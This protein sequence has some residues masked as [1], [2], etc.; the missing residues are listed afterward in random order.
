MLK[1]IKR[2]RNLSGTLVA[3]FSLLT[4]A[5]SGQAIQTITDKNDILIGEQ[6]RLKIKATLPAGLNGQLKWVVVPD[7]VAHFE[8]IE[9][10][11]MDT[12][13]YKDDSRSIEQT[14]VVTSFDSGRWAFP[15]LPLEYSASQGLPLQQLQTD[16]FFVNVTYSPPDS[17]N[18]LRDIKPIMEVTVKSYLWYYVGG[19]IL[20]LLVAA[21][22]LW[23][24]L[25]YRKKKPA[26]L[27]TGKSSPYDEAMSALKKLKQ[28]NL[29]D[30]AD[31]KL[32]H[33]SLA[34]IFKWYISRRQRYS[35]MN[36]TTGDV[37][38]YLKEK[39]LSNEAVA[40]IAMAMRCGDAVKFAK[41]LPPVIESNE[42][43][44]KITAVL[45]SLQPQNTNTKT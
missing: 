35:I 12:I 32:F 4:I 41:Y 17:T 23:R 13:S 28:L 6:I 36:K 10:G 18:Q 26:L 21:F 27:F 16:S 8:I 40:A 1:G 43:L 31:I 33:S 24:Y 37:L 3:V 44:D 20:L 11:K 5:G 45:D 2:R 7:S 39:N 9:T 42:C 30:V 19:G 29:Q 34:E 14:L 25:K 22:F 38:V 15:S